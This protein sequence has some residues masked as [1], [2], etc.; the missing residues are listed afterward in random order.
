MSSTDA[1]VAA[2]PTATPAAPQPDPLNPTVQIIGR[3]VA[4]ENRC[5]QFLTSI[6]TQHTSVANLNNWVSNDFADFRRGMEATLD[7]LTNRL[8][9]MDQ[10]VARTQESCVA[11][12]QA[13]NVLQAGHN[14]LHKIIHDS[15]IGEEDPTRRG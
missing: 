1:T 15:A 13:G 11:L 2:M 3:I 8:A 5:D 14:D 10:L 12:T 9:E 7:R 6:Q 4:I